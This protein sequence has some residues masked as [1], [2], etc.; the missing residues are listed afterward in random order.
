MKNMKKLVSSVTLALL[1]LGATVLTG[2]SQNTPYG[3]SYTTLTVPMP[4]GPFAAGVTTNL[5]SGWASIVSVTNT[6]TTWNSSSNAFVTAT[7][8]VS[9]TNTTYAD[10]SVNSQ[11]DCLVIITESAGI[12]TN[13]VTFAPIL[14]D[15][16]T[17][18]NNTGTLTLKHAAASTTTASTNFPATWIGGAYGV[19]V[20]QLAWTAAAAAVTNPVVKYG[21]ING[22]K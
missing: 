14:S 19:R 6:S 3:S 7:N 11:K 16:T 1:A 2:L 13:V 5:A 9:A 12:G 17:D 20:T 21:K 8:V 22:A 10:L 18:T 4:T 15:G